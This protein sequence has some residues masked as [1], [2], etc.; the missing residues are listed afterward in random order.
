[1]LHQRKNSPNVDG[2]S[3]KHQD[4]CDFA[5]KYTTKSIL[6]TLIMI[7]RK[8]KQKMFHIN[9]CAKEIE[10]LKEN[11]HHHLVFIEKQ[12]KNIQNLV[13]TTN[14]KLIVAPNMTSTLKQKDYQR[15]Y[16]HNTQYIHC[17]LGNKNCFKTQTHTTQKQKT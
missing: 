15:S 10:R 9:T 7:N 17:S 14:K 13:V 3:A 5:T 8:Q 16:S 6:G 12:K 11:H 1:M 4:Y 2:I